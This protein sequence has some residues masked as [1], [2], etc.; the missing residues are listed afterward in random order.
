MVCEGVIE[1]VV[2]V[3]GIV[4]DCIFSGFWFCVIQWYYNT[5]RCHC[6]SALYDWHQEICEA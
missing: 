1:D 5:L 6:Y 4:T 3:L 2:L